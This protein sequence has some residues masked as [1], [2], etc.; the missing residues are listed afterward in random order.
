MRRTLAGTLGACLLASAAVAAADFWQEKAFTD[1]SAPQ[2]EKLLSDS[3]WAKK[4][5]IVT[6]SLREQGPGGGFDSG[7]AGLGGG[8]GSRDADP[9]S[10][11]FQGL[12]RITVTVVWSSALPIR[13][14][15]LRRQAGPEAITADQQQRLEENEPFYS[16][17]VVG[18]PSSVTAKVGTLDEVKTISGLTPNRKE[19]I[20]PEEIRVFPH[21]DRS[22]RVEFLFP[23]SYA[24]A[25]EDKEVEF[26]TKLGDA[27]I[28]KKFKLS[29]MAVRG[30]LAL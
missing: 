11:E 23:K 17:T 19:R 6:G 15:L 1:W 18:L 3:P 27:D 28:V 4:V 22:V 16:V 5:T 29:D 14:A 26:T 25:L 30:R 9:G 12:R 13:Q 2:I 21:A 7:S 20:A 24:L 8:G 10:G